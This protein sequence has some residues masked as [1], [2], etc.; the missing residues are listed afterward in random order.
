MGRRWIGIEMG[1]QARTHCLPRLQ[2]VVEGE[3]GGI[4]AA[5]GWHGGGGFSFVQLGEAV[6]DEYGRIADA[7]RFAPLAAWLWFAHTRA[8]HP[9]GVFDSP[10]LGVFEGTA[11]VLLY[12][13]ILGDKRPQGGNV[14]TR[15]VW[16]DVAQLLPDHDG[17]WVI[18]GEACRLSADTC[19][20]AGI[21]FRYIPHD[22]G[23]R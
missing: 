5:V 7:V 3:Q 6:F 18:F 1:E 4:S 12:N 20:R 21:D 13:G 23:I 22:L 11:F 19:K 15:A 9:V 8:P 10:L 17:P 16:Q 2:K 14:L